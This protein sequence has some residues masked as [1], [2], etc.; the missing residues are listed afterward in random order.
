ML[1]GRLAGS[2]VVLTGQLWSGVCFWQHEL[3]RPTKC[4]G[5]SLTSY[6][7]GPNVTD[8]LFPIFLLVGM[9]W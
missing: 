6:S 9:S 1:P 2:P 8:A 4:D 7:D 3:F 5:D